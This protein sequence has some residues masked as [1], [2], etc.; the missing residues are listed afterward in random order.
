MSKIRIG[1]VGVGG[2]GQAAHLRNYVT[3]PEC[4]VVAIA[5]LRPKM[6]EAIQ[7]RYGIANAYADHRE[8]L[9]KERLDG[10]VAPQPYGLHGKLVPDLLAAGVPVLTEKPI[11]R[12]IEVA[13]ALVKASAAGKGRL[14]IGYHKRSDPASTHAKRTIAAL[15]ASGELGKMTYVRVCMPPGDWV[16]N[17]FVH[18]INTDDAYPS[19]P[20]DADPVGMDA[21]TTAEHESFVN[22]YI[23]QVNL[24]RFLY[25]EGYEVRYADP[26]GVVMHVAS[27]SG[28]PGV[29]EMAP[30][31]TTVDWQEHALV[32]FER[33]WVRID[34]PAPLAAHR[35]GTVTIFKDP[36]NGVAPT[37]TVPTM[38]WDHAMAA[39]AANFIR[40]CR[41]EATDLCRPEDARD[42]MLVA[43]RYIALRQAARAQLAGRSATGKG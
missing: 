10:I 22:Y 19:T 17:G 4:E 15:Q 34:L 31:N 11:G 3:N 18:N 23:H 35:C 36:G 41:G 12:S 20:G 13:E 32:C 39:Q 25:G 40:A 28:V 8:M 16:A 43:K 1:F 14:F 33:G 38:P 37:T 24:L 29:L 2:M 27:A 6:R 42:D 7:R 9:A 5:E 26:A 30:F 21:A